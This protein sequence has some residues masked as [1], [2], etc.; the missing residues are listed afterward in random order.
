MDEEKEFISPLEFVRISG[1]SM[2]SV[3]RRLATG[4]LPKLQFGGDRCRVLIPRSALSDVSC[5]PL[6]KAPQRPDST[7]DSEAPPAPSGP[8]PRWKDRR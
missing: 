4:D 1:L 8:V 5:V 3:R 2:S 7:S 6:A